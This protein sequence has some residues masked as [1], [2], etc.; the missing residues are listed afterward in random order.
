MRCFFSFLT[1]LFCLSTAF[2]AGAQAPLPAAGELTQSI[3]QKQY[4]R[5]VAQMHPLRKT[6]SVT[7][8]RLKA[9]GGYNLQD[10]L[11]MPKG[12]SDSGYY[13]YSRDNTSAFD[14]Q[15]MSYAAP[16]LS[17]YTSPVNANYPFSIGAQVQSLATSATTV[18]ADTQYSWNSFC[19]F[20]VG[21]ADTFGFA[22]IVS[23]AYNQGK[24]SEG[25]FKYYPT[26]SGA[27]YRYQVFYDTDGQVSSSF[28]SLYN[29]FSGSWDTSLTEFISYDGSGNMVV[30]S[31]ASFA[32]GVWH[33][34]TK[35][36]YAYDLPGNLIASE[37]FTDS[38]G[39]WQP[40]VQHH[41]SY[42]TDTT[43]ASDSVSQYNAG[44]WSSFTKDSFG[45]STGIPYYT[46][47]QRTMYLADTAYQRCEYVKHITAGLPDTVYYSYY[48]GYFAQPSQLLVS[49]K[50]VFTYNSPGD[51]LTA[52]AFN[53]S[54]TDTLTGSGSYNTQPE[55][56]F[57]YYYEQYDVT[58]V[59][60]EPVPGNALIVYPNPA[61]DEVTIVLSESLHSAASI[62]IT[63]ARGRLVT[64]I[65]MPQVNLT[66][67]VSLEG[68]APGLYF[69]TVSNA[70]SVVGTARM[71]KQ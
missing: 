60:T 3:L 2:T 46:Y 24:V 12:K 26:V 33:P 62:Q 51:P 38:S 29:N 17:T 20:G 67:R 23:C 11:G 16:G 1:A 32:G 34:H 31:V 43:L 53:F 41:L 58:A 6:T 36:T 30:D 15:A 18:W 50:T 64:T 25:L 13:I 71:V 39:Y 42:N 44:I 22:A 66:E 28:Y 70:G 56:S 7:G 21:G 55:R 69:V 9:F 65:A 57:Y 5:R 14:Y 35:N 4:M 52:N 8:E 54:I 37:Y 63:D 49:K 61:E 19:P 59:K 40:Q 48:G 47:A 10:T 27:N 45:Y 68:I